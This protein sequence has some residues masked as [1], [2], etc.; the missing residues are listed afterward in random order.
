M[1][2]YSMSKGITAL[3]MHMLQEDGLIS[4]SG[5]VAFYALEFAREGKDNHYSTDTG[6]PWRYPRA[7]LKRRY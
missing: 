6:A 7:A 5:P 3:L 2:L 1:C 4:L